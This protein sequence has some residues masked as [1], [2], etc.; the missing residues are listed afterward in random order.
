M[1]TER[2]WRHQAI[3][4]PAGVPLTPATQFHTS[5]SPVIAAGCTGPQLRAGTDHLRRRYA[6]HSAGVPAGCS[7]TAAS[8]S[9]RPA[10]G[11]A[12]ALSAQTAA[13]PRSLPGDASL[14]AT[15]P[16]G[17]PASYYLSILPGDSANAFNTANT[18]DPSIAGN[19]AA[20]TQPTE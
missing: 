17:T 20:G 13:L 8:T 15:N 19:C 6:L 2:R 14:T 1:P 5:Y 7:A 3:D 9:R 4:L 10:T 12:F 16:N 11:T 18:S